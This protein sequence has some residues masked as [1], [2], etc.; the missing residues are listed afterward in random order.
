MIKSTTKPGISAR[1]SLCAIVTTFSIKITTAKMNPIYDTHRYCWSWSPSSDWK[2]PTVKSTETSVESVAVM[3]IVL[4][5]PYSGANVTIA[6]VM[7]LVCA[8][9]K[10]DV[11]RGNPLRTRIGASVILWRNS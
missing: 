9:M 11:S 7:D 10:V 8:S 1:T 2:C 5:S 4:A 3:E 6:T